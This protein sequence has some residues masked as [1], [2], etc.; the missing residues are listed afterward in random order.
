MPAPRPG[1]TEC[2][3]GA[4]DR[5]R[6]PASR[7]ATG[8]EDETGRT[9]LPSNGRAVRT[10]MIRTARFP[11]RGPGMSVTDETGA[12]SLSRVVSRR[13]HQPDVDP[14]AHDHGMAPQQV[15]IG[16]MMGVFCTR[17]DGSGRPCPLGHVL[18]RQTGLV[19]DTRG[20]GGCAR[21][22][23]F[24]LSCAD[25]EPRF[26]KACR[27]RVC[28]SCFSSLSVASDLHDPDCPC[29]GLHRLVIFS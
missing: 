7:H 22:N 24:G 8:S 19:P 15:E 12:T 9:D 20:S 13:A 21:P 1:R 11:H 3:F 4:H 2:G 25:G 6:A 18:L 16:Q 14:P 26:L 27:S 23:A 28:V 17:N 29:T 10:C 5:E